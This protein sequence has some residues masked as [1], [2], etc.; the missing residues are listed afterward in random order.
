MLRETTKS[1]VSVAGIPAEI[2]T[3]HFPNMLELQSPAPVDS[4]SDIHINQIYRE[5]YICVTLGN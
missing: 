1:S 4:G 5:R 3:K 2:R